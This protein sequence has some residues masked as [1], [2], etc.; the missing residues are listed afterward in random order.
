MGGI[1]ARVVVVELVRLVGVL[2]SIGGEVG[3]I[4]ISISDRCVYRISSILSTAI[5]AILAAS[6]ISVMT[7]KC[8]N[9]K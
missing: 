2:G 9:W 3:S 8:Y 4:S 5:S 1:L 7:V 6:A